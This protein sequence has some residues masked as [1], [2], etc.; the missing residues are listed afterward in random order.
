MDS[1]IVE[2]ILKE[3]YYQED[4]SCWEDIANRVANYIGNDNVS[5]KEYFD[6]INKKEIIP[7]SPCL[8]NAG[9]KQGGSLSACFSV[10][11]DDSIDG[12]FDSV[13]ACAKIHK[14]GGGTGISLSAIRGSGSP[15]KGTGH[16]ASGPVSFMHVFN[17][18]TETIKQ[19]GKRRGANMGHLN[20]D[21]PDILEFI[22]CKE[23][24]G[25]LSNFNISINITDKFMKNLSDPK[26]K[27]IFDLI[28]RG[29]WRNGEP[30]IIFSDTAEK[31]NKCPHLGKLTDT[32]PCCETRLFPWESCNLASINLMACVEDGKFNWYKFD[33][34]ISTGVRFLDDMIDKN[35][36]P[37]PKIEEATKKTRK[38]GLGVMGFAD[39]LISLGIKYGDEESFKFTDELFKFM[40]NV[41]DRESAEIAVYKGVYPV[42][43][44]DNRRNAVVLSIA[45]TGSI[46]LFAGVSSGIEPNFGWVYNRSTWVDGEKKTY[47]MLHPLFE[48]ICDGMD[49]N[50]L[51]WSTNAINYALEHGTMK[52]S[53]KETYFDN[54]VVA[55]DISPMDHIRMQAVIQKHVDQAISKTINCKSSTTE[56]DIASMIVAAWKLGCKGF[57]IYREGSRDDVVLETNSGK[58]AIVTPVSNNPVM[59]LIANGNG[60]ILPKTPRSMMSITEKR[61]SSCGKLYIT[62]GE[63]DSKPH[64][65]LIKNKGG[66]CT[67]MIQTVAELTAAMLRWK[68]PRWELVRILN[69]IKCEACLKNP[70]ADGRSCSD[71][72]GKVLRENYPDE[73][74]PNKYDEVEIAEQSTVVINKIACPKCGK[75]LI[76]SEGCRSCPECG[77]S[78]CS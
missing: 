27:E 8:M 48:E 30:G 35:V 23:V 32:N 6:A 40:R 7:N 77:Y 51:N 69:G 49:V 45:P 17:A 66:G 15:V 46:S 24:E 44:N 10:P 22:K 13:K 26:N 19:G 47:N 36:Y 61:N 65:V 57:T 63:V 37:L 42:A 41:A 58:S 34:L 68:I 67:A 39:L 21:H 33:S 54:F 52:D 14:Q 4:E 73:E 9:T 78:H 76:F 2:S 38:I 60:R 71:I 74:I 11:V 29:N 31:D 43:K 64:T 25:D 5:C 16:C 59:A 12:I 1:S 18:A 20:V 56:S 3:R 70:K 75:S 72:I 62:I 50:H 53:G 55:K 28:V